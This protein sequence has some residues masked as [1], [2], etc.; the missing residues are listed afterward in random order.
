MIRPI[1]PGDADDLQRF[2]QT[3]SHAA[4]RNRFWSG[5]A[6]LSPARLKSFT[7]SDDRTHV[8][9]VAVIHEDG[10]RAIIAEAQSATDP[11]GRGDCAL[12]VSDAWQ[13]RGLGRLLMEQLFEAARGRDTAML[14]CVTQ[15]DNEAM[16]GL[17]L[18]A[19]YARAP[20]GGDHGVTRFE[21]AVRSLVP[22]G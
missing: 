16:R 2:V 4:R 18:A 13:R 15:S 1:V 10:A 5:L 7:E 6:A 19:G 12:V 14:V 17:A 9:L 11:G 21:R 8:G 20:N 22:R 3:L